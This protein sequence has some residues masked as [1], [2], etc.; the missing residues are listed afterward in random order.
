MTPLEFDASTE[1][2]RIYTNGRS[3]RWKKPPAY[4]LPVPV[5]IR[6]Y[7]PRNAG[8]G[9]A[10]QQPRRCNMQ[11]P[12]Q[13]PI[14]VALIGSCPIKRNFLAPQPNREARG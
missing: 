6:A 5:A 14:T 12:A 7:Q 8:N 10:H 11:Y 1:A 3:G 13:I 2:P 4:V 9:P